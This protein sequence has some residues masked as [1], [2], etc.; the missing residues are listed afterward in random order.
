LRPILPRRTARCLVVDAGG[1][2]LLLRWLDR[3]DG[4]VVWLTPGGGV[5]EGETASEA[6]GREL[7]E[8]V[9]IAAAP[10]GPPVMHQVV[11]FDDVLRDEDHFVVQFDGM[12]GRAS[13]PDP[14]TEGWR[15]WSLAELETSTER[16]HPHNVARLLRHVAGGRT[17]LIE[18]AHVIS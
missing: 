7:M 13:A 3:K 6:A 1:R 4:R 2:V 10:V 18:D 9:G 15:W 16:F 17:D 11:W 14:G 8:E 12:W 5:E